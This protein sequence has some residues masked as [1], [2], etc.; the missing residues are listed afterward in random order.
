[1]TGA[2]NEPSSLR[3]SR[4]VSLSLGAFTLFILFIYLS[5]DVFYDEWE[6]PVA[7]IVVIVAAAV[8]WLAGLLL[9]LRQRSPRA[10]V[11]LA[12]CPTLLLA[13]W[14]AFLD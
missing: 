1:M 2:G 12:A 6:L 8:A 10:V 14:L 3:Y 13:F 11:A 4:F 5:G 7:A 9:T